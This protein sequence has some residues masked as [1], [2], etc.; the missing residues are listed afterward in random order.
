[1]KSIDWTVFQLLHVKC[2]FLIMN[3]PILRT[4]RQ[5]AS[6]SIYQ[7][8]KTTERT[9][10]NLLQRNS[11]IRNNLQKGSKTEV[12]ENTAKM[13]FVK[14]IIIIRHFSHTYGNVTSIDIIMLCIP[15]K[16]HTWMVIYNKRLYLVSKT[17]IRLS[18]LSF[19]C[20]CHVTMRKTLLITSEQSVLS[21]WLV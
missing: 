9:V 1:M 5:K 15:L 17:E 21:K 6:W 18:I 11:W 4:K 2:H 19:L 12:S 14:F 3:E 7:N 10:R 20:Y 8:L 13:Q 16:Y